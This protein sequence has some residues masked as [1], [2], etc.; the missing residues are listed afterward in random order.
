MREERNWKTGD[1][2][3]FARG[4]LQL[5]IVTGYDRLPANLIGHAI[6]HPEHGVIVA[7]D[8]RDRVRG[9]N[10]KRLKFAKQKKSKRVVEIGAGKNYAS[11]GGSSRSVAGMKF[12]AGFNL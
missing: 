11:D 3:I 8:L 5:E 4:R 12:G 7:Q 9:I 6:Q 1:S 2:G 10:L